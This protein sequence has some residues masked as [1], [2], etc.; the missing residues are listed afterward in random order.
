MRSV[1]QSINRKGRG[2]GLPH[3]SSSAQ[4]PSLRRRRSRLILRPKL[5]HR[6][7]PRVV[8]L[9][10][11]KAGRV[12]ARVVFCGVTVLLLGHRVRS[13]C[14]RGAGQM[15]FI[16]LDCWA[17]DMSRL[18]L[19]FSF[20]WRDSTWTQQG[21]RVAGMASARSSTL[22]KAALI[23]TPHAWQEQRRRRRQQ[24]RQQPTLAG[25]I[26]ASPIHVLQAMVKLLYLQGSGGG[27]N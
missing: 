23:Q 13:A 14:R 10:R 20:C 1:N 16:K 19:V 7:V 8:P 25:L 22:P 18:L 24:R 21:S 17:A 11:R 4:P 6:H 15:A 27:S 5:Q 2:E 9:Y 26:A 12:P 3:G